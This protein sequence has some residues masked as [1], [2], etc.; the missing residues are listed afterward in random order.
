MFRQW[1]SGDISP[2]DWAFAN[3][4][5]PNYRAEAIARTESIRA[6]N[7]STNGLFGKWKVPARE[8]VA[9]PDGRVRESHMMMDGQVQ[10]TGTPF[11]SPY[12]GAKLMY[13]GD[14]AAPVEETV[15]CRCAI[16]AVIR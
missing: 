2:E 13:P 12:S 11:E 4:R 8:W 10:P 5:L 3:V 15:N 1:I 14:P 6:S 7:A 16:V 9:T